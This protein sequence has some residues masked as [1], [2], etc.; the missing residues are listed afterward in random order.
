MSNIFEKIIHKR[1]YNILNYQN[2]CY[3]SQFVFRQKHNYGLVL[4][5]WLILLSESVLCGTSGV[6]GSDQTSL[7]HLNTDLSIKEWGVA[8]TETNQSFYY[9]SHF[10][11]PSVYRFFLLFIWNFVILFLFSFQFCS[12]HYYYCFILCII[13]YALQFQINYLNMEWMINAI[14]VCCYF[15]HAI[16]RK[17]L[18]KNLN[19]LSV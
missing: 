17:I 16:R 11:I 3:Q 15:D 18:M 10:P 8:G 4:F 5:A 2:I 14:E 9:L 12:G 13:Y 1:V 19:E 6:Q 7:C